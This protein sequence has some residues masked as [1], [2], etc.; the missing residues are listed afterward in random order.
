MFIGGG[1][2]AFRGGVQFNVAPYGKEGGGVIFGEKS[3]YV[4]C[5]RLVS[6]ISSCN[7]LHVNSLVSITIHP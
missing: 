5:E 7:S 2:G 1:G 4:V 6:I 3:A